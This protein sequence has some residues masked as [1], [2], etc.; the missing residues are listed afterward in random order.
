MAGGVGTTR[1]RQARVGFAERREDLQDRR[2]S[3]ED[4]VLFRTP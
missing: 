2:S 1:S 4:S 3:T